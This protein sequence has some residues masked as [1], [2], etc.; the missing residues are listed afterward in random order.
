HQHILAGLV[1]RGVDSHVVH[2]VSEMY[3]NITTYIVTKNGKTDPINI[4][5]GV[6]QGDPMSPF[7]FNLVL[8]P[9]LCK[10]E[11]DGEGFHLGRFKLT[12]M[13]FAD[14]LVLLSNSWEGMCHNIRI[15]ETFCDFTGLRT[16]G[17]K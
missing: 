13:A 5:S 10:L 3:R 7:L 6:K 11:A 4:C 14:D 16:Q 1:Q 8:D 2:L 17:E 9:L 12:A 15:L